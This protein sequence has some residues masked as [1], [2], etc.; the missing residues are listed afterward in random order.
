MSCG[1]RGKL[2]PDKTKLHNG[3]KAVADQIHG[4]GLKFGTVQWVY[5]L[6]FSPS[7]L[8]CHLFHC[9][10]TGS[11]TVFTLIATYAHVCQASTAT[12]AS[13]AAPVFPVAR[14][15]RLKM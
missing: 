10:L 3:V 15:A 1:A 4:L 14:D 7:D 11:G 5:L 12:P 2:Q 8:S 9:C 6:P 13:S